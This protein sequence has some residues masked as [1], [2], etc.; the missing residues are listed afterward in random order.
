M[1]FW[2]VSTMFLLCLR[3]VFSCRFHL[4]FPFLDCFQ[5]V[6]CSGVVISSK[7]KNPNQT[8]KQ[9]KKPAPKDSGTV[10]M[11]I[12]HPPGLR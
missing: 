3:E 8:N 6:L 12:N 10:T 9:T 11:S 2:Y 4:L 5:L 1:Y 7:K